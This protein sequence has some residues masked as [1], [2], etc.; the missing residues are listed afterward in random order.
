[1]M[2]LSLKEGNDQ[3]GEPYETDKFNIKNGVPDFRMKL[4]NSFEENKSID[5]FEATWHKSDTTNLTL[6]YKK[7]K[8]MASCRLL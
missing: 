8:K 1:M 7:G 4:Y 6:W 2:K 3:Y 5:I